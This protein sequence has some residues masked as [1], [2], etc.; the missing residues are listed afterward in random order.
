MNAIPKPL[1]ALALALSAVS[2]QR[3]AG[4]KKGG[5]SVPAAERRRTLTFLTYN[6][7]GDRVVA[8]ERVERLLEVIREADPD[9]IALQEVAPWFYE[10]LS[11]KPWV[12]EGYRGTT[13]HG[14]PLVPKGLYILS[15]IPIKK[16]AHTW[17]PSRQGRMVL[18][19]YLKVNGRWLA[20]G[21]VHLES[22]LRSGPARAKQL[23]KVFP[24]L[25]KSDDAV[26]LGDFNFGH[27]EE[28][29]TSHLNRRYKDAWL[30][31]RGG[32]PGFTWDIERNDLARRGSFK[33]ETSRRIDRILVRSDVW[34]L[35]SIRIIGD[36]PVSEGGKLFPSDHFGLVATL[37]C[38]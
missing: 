20:V 14:R 6:V 23:D 10:R 13:V 9:V 35:K 11:K 25:A 7:L 34:R 12:A 28:P 31:R 2:C 32:E 24:L 16:L 4:P 29:E 36:E 37:E 26:L 38:E 30:V 19:A 33:G 8:A 21:T 27:E 18:V 1:V 15:R 5:R 17:L 22:P 3:H